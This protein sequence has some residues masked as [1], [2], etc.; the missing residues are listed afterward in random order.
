MAAVSL[1]SLTDAIAAPFSVALDPHGVV[2]ISTPG[3]LAVSETVFL[4]VPKE[5][6]KGLIVTQDGWQPEA[7]K[8]SADGDSWT[9]TGRAS[10]DGG[11]M[12]ITQTV[13][14]LGDHVVVEYRCRVADDAKE[15]KT[16]GARLIVRV[17]T[18]PF[19]GRGRFLYRRGP[20]IFAHR[21]PAE[22]P[23]RYHLLFL[24]KVD[25]TGWAVDEQGFINRH[26]GDWLEMIALQDDR[27][28]DVDAFEVQMVI[29]G[30]QTLRAGQEFSCRLEIAA[31]PLEKIVGRSV[32]VVEVENKWEWARV[33]LKSQ[34]ELSIGQVEW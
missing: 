30:T 1:L 23:E 20:A 9:V 3:P 26:V 32:P 6:W 2:K 8:Q 22:L 4:L 13:R 14:A 7:I 24:S 12:Q 10:W 31:G 34:G 18:D 25:A 21:L 11:A 33:D 17:P 28:F 19:A 5:Q 27:K 29:A 15:I 16:A